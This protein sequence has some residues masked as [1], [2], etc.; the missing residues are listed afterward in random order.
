MSIFRWPRPA[1]TPRRD[2]PQGACV[3]AQIEND[4]RI[5]SNRKLGD[6][7]RAQALRFLIHFVADIHQPLHAEDND[8]KGGNQVRVTIGRERANLHRVWDAD[9]VEV[10]GRDSALAAEAILRAVSPAQHQAW[11]SGTPTG[12]ANEAHAIA[13]D[14]IY[15]S[16]MGRH[17]L[18]LP[19]DYAWRQ[20]GLARMQLA[21]AGIRL[22]WLLNNILK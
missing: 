16:L 13:R 11:A 9:V 18:R 20:A 1:M 12:W 15:P 4:L 14:Q 21:K 22:A 5:L 8:D 17:D 7:A 3:V 19:R 10:Q 2:C 6:G